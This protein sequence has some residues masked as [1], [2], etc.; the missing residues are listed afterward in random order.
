MGVR[1]IGQ[2]DSVIAQKITTSKSFAIFNIVL[3]LTILLYKNNL[4]DI[5][6]TFV[7]F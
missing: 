7:V 1:T 6:V 4:R 5:L 3:N 2:F